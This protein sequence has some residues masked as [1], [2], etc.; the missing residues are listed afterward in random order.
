MSIKLLTTNMKLD[1]I[2][3]A[4]AQ[5]ADQ[6][7]VSLSHE[8]VSVVAAEISV[9]KG[10]GDISAQTISRVLR[11]L[12]HAEKK[13]LNLRVAQ[14]PSERRP[15]KRARQEVKP[16][17]RIDYAAV[18]ESLPPK[19]RTRQALIEAAKAVRVRP[20]MVES[21]LFQHPELAKR[22]DSTRSFLTCSRPVK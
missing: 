1:L 8:E 21:F 13:S 15:V 7:L 5:L 10:W 16:I 9:K 11:R 3:A 22:L 17:C 12:T 19:K 14:D 6:G 4:S 18:I 20:W 2:R